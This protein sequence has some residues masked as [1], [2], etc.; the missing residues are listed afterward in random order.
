MQKKIGHFLILLIVCS[1]AQSQ[2]SIR[3]ELGDKQEII[4]DTSGRMI[5]YHSTF[6]TNQTQFR[7]KVKTPRNLYHPWISMLKQSLRETKIRLDEQDVANAYACLFKNDSNYVFFKK[8][9]DRILALPDSCDKSTLMAAINGLESITVEDAIKITDTIIVTDTIQQQNPDTIIIRQ[10][11]EIKERVE[12]KLRTIQAD[13]LFIPIQHLIRNVENQYL[14]RIYRNDICID[15]AW[16]NISGEC[17]KGCAE[18]ASTYRKLRNEK[19]V[20]CVATSGDEVRFELIHINPWDKAIRD[21][22]KIKS[23]QFFERIDQATLQMVMSALDTLATTSSQSSFTRA[24]RNISHLNEWFLNWF[25]FNGGKLSVD[26]FNVLTR[27]GRNGI[28]KDLASKDSGIAILNE[29]AAF[30]NGAKSALPKNV[31]QLALLDSIQALQQKISKQIDSIAS[32]KLVLQ[33]LLKEDPFFTRLR[34]KTMAY[35]GRVQPS[36]SFMAFTRRSVNPHKQFDAFKNY[37]PVVLNFFERRKITE[38]PENERMYLAVHNVPQGI[39][40]KFDER[41]V[42]FSDDEQ[43][44]ALVKEQLAQINFS[45]LGAATVLRLED[46]I[47]SLGAPGGEKLAPKG[48]AVTDSACMRNLQPFVKDFSKMI[49]KGYITFPPDPSLFDQLVTTGPVFRTQLN[50]ITTFEPP[51]R[52]S[53]TIK[54]I[55]KDTT[56]DVAKTYVK[57]GRLRF[58]EL[59]AGIAVTRSPVSVT[60]VDT[61]GNGFKVSS[62]DNGAKAIFGFKI[63]PFRNYRRDHSIIPRYPLR[64]LSVLAGFELLHPLNNFYIGAAYDVVPGLAVSIG[65]NYFLQTRYRVENNIITNTSRSYENSGTYYSVTINPELFIQFVKLFFK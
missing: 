9:I 4:F 57:V 27:T 60:T 20:S 16:L 51:F 3:Q 17:G 34:S 44:T 23:N 13:T 1:K 48:A 47:R 52:D 40:L 37:Q 54:A 11:T 63:Y 62:S 8:S 42:A 22:Y 26:P 21:W 45:T 24:L 14:V 15:S 38:I 50:P 33:N 36:R 49:K 32:E 46:F 35:Q 5:S 55:S 65:E 39:T 53:I 59:M 2:L 31:A 41:R 61:S 28:A 29:K 43:F 64:R 19:C 10:R 6:V 7:F 25:W 12:K 58:I 56:V 18:F 30:L